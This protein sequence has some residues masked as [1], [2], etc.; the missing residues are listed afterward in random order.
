M[1]GKSA[2]ASIRPEFPLSFSYAIYFCIFVFG[3]QLTMI[4]PLLGTM[5]VTFNRPLSM[6]GILISMSSAGFM[7]AIVIGGIVADRIGKKAV[8]KVA[9]IGFGLCLMLFAISSGFWQACVIIFLIGGFGGVLE[10]LLSSL[11]ADIRPGKERAAVTLTQVFFGAGAIAGPAAAGWMI[12]LS[13]PWQM[14]YAFVGLLAL[15]SAVW[16]LRYTYPSVRPEERIRGT[17]ILVILRNGKFLLLCLA[18][19]LYVGVEMSVTAW[20]PN[21]FK[22]EFDFSGSTSG[23]ILSLFWVTMTLGRFFFSWLSLLLSNRILVRGLSALAGTGFVLL[24]VSSGPFM[25][26]AS[27]ILIGV[28]MSAV[29]PLIVAEAGTLFDSRYSGTSFSIVIAA[30]GIGGAIIPLGTGY[31][32]EWLPMRDVFVLLSVFVFAII[33]IH[34]IVNKANS[35][36]GG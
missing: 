9:S 28:G 19:A 15:L 34:Y 1:M 10:S 3:M 16:L 25:G 24:G 29:W 8:I 31:F 13:I 14:A 11:S 20:S 30:G 35:Q 33:L 32:S 22:V 6:M 5:S 17:D 27:L 21:Y 18:L 26:I 4:G 2:S 7:S 36:P 12:R 23:Y